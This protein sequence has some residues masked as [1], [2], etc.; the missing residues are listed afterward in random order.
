[1]WLVAGAV[2][3]GRLA[4]VLRQSTHAI[5]Q[6]RPSLDSALALRRDLDAG[7]TT[8]E[9]IAAARSARSR[10]IALVAGVTAAL[11]DS[12]FL[13]ALTLTPEGTVRVAGLAP[14]PARVVTELE[15]VPLLGAVKLEG[16]VTRE[17]TASGQ[18]DR[19]AIAGHM[20][21]AP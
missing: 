4:W 7:R 21:S 6:A 20:E 8:L 19:F 5:V 11:E 16:P 18:R 14:S 1:M 9:T 13:V 3:V 2:Y 10:T 15:G 17:T 12:A